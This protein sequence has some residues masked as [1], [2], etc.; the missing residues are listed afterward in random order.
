MR[1]ENDDE[2][3]RQP[4]AAPEGVLVEV[5]HTDTGAA[6]CS[7]AGE[8]DIELMEPAERALA[9]LVDARPPVLVVGLAEVTFCDSSGLNLLLKTRA[10]AAAAGIGF[11]LA[12]VPPT[13]MRVLE[14]TGTQAVF[15]LHATVDEALAA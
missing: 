9:A 3:V 7:I 11:R 14:L 1:P 8:L 6:L 15:A 5:R 10:A 13:V 12:A 4:A 2:T